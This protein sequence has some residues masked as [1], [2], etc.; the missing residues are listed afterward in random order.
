MS[1]HPDNAD[2]DNSDPDGPEAPMGQCTMQ[3]SFKLEADGQ[4][5]ECE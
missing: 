4:T 3:L 5:M 2:P 1:H